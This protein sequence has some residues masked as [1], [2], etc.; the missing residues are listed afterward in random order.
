[1]AQGVTVFIQG[2]S[3]KAFQIL[4]GEIYFQI[5]VQDQS[6]QSYVSL[7]AQSVPELLSASFSKNHRLRVWT[8]SEGMV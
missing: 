3:Q 8:V 7:F 2:L 4:H 5:S 6:T 1:M